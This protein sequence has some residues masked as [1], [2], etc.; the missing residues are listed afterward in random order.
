MELPHL[1]YPTRIKVVNSNPFEPYQNFG[2]FGTFLLPQNLVYHRFENSP[3]VESQVK[4]VEKVEEPITQK[5]EE[6]QREVEV[7]KRLEGEA[8]DR[9]TRTAIPD[10]SLKRSFD[11]ARA[12]SKAEKETKK[13]FKNHIK[14]RKTIF[15]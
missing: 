11:L 3:S 9:Q 5:E 12:V 7:P 6:K 1:K 10:E 2:G 8:T 15:D 14:K 13:S 4:I